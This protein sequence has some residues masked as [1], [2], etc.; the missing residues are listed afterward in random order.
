MAQ[1]GGLFDGGTRE[2]KAPRKRNLPPHSNRMYQH[3]IPW[4]PTIWYG[5]EMYHPHPWLY[6]GRAYALPWTER[7]L[8]K[9]IRDGW[10]LDSGIIVPE[11]IREQEEYFSWGEV[12]GTGLRVTED[13]RPGDIVLFEP[14]TGIPD[15]E[16]NV[17]V[18]QKHIWLVL[19]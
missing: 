9:E 13:L 2:G 15:G 6:E 12:M 16:G 17:F 5:N 11:Y 7:V 3:Q 10:K 14:M 18:W 4:D 8:V 1:T 19:G